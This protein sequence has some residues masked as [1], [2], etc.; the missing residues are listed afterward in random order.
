M[1]INAGYEYISAEKAYLQA[2][3]LEQRIE[4]L[5]EMIRA[6]PKHKSSENFVSELKNRLRR[7]EEKKEKNKKVGKSSKKGIKKE[8]YQCVL[9]GLT[10]S[11]KSCLLSK[12]TNAQPRISQNPFTTKEPSI[13]TMDYDGFKV[14]MVDTPSIGSEYFDIG[15]VNTADCL[16]MVIESLTDLEKINPYLAK[17]IGNKIIAINKADRYSENEKRKLNDNLRSK[18]VHGLLVSCLTGEGLEELKKKITEGMN[19]IRVYTKE[20]GKQSTGI[21]VTLP[22]GSTVR[23]IAESILKGFSKKVKETKLTGPSSKFPN[24]KVG[25]AHILKDRDVVEFRTH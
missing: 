24:Q 3:T 20:P 4:C 8:G 16:L 1:P 18:K 22:Q 25:L 6:A 13:G 5:K 10:N 12:L 15:I 7:F 11:G 23:D 17:T 21:P 9:L 19:L 14:Q 2:Q